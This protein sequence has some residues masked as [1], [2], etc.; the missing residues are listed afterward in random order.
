MPKG[1]YERKPKDEP[2]MTNE[3]AAPVQP[4]E[5]MFPVKLLKNYRP[6]GSYE[7][8]GY[9]RPE[10]VQKD[11][12]G[13]MVVVQEAAFIEGEMAPPPFPGVG[14][15]TKIWAETVLRL[16]MEEAKSLVGKRL[17]ERADAIPG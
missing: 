4:S 2:Q 13:K 3:T 7:L 12:A 10:K 5:K 16:P 15:E 11:T 9:H 1:V 17:A 14:F 8:V 6:D